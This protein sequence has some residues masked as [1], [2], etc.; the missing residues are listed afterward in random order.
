MSVSAAAIPRLRDQIRA[1]ELTFQLNR[2]FDE[3]AEIWASQHLREFTI[4]NSPHYLQ[5]EQN[6]DVITA[7][8]Q[9]TEHRLTEHEIF[10]LLAA[11]HL[12]DIGMQ[13]GV[14]DARAK[15]AQYAFELILH[16]SVWIDA[17]RRQVTLSLADANAREAIAYVARAHWTEFALDLRRSDYIYGNVFGRLRLLGLLLAN[18][19][20]LDTS[21]IRA[22]YFRSSHRLFALAP[23]AELHQKMHSLIRGFGIVRPHPELRDQLIYE[24]KWRDSSETVRLLADWQLRW[25][26]SQMRQIIPGLEIESGGAIRW[27]S[28]WA[29]VFFRDPVGPTEQ[30]GTKAKALLLEDVR[31]QKRIDRDALAERFHEALTNPGATVFLL[32]GGASSD[33]RHVTDWCEAHARS[34]DEIAVARIAASPTDPVDT[35]ALAALAL[36]DWGIESMESEVVGRAFDVFKATLRRDVALVLIAL[37]DG[38][39]AALDE[40]I[41]SFAREVPYPN[42]PRVLVLVTSEVPPLGWGELAV[43]TYQ[44]SSLQECDVDEYLRGRYGYATSERRALI[45]GI[46]ALDLLQQPSKLYDYIHHHCDRTAWMIEEE[47]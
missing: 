2:I 12:H 37:R 28:P 9:T 44:L 36:R 17:E 14:P 46:R 22:G 23:I 15:H 43:A 34:E 30:L 13:L 35:A 18:A 26:S 24:L 32:L 16:S 45:E 25:F 6:L 1:P 40:V 33:W 4:H 42:V 20:L 11:C 3:A 47:L 10:V 38:P 8:L 21:A 41:Q 7:H 29:R 19:D 31:A 27:A 5:V 39:S